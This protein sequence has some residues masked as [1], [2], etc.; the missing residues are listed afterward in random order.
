[1]FTAEKGFL[2]LEAMRILCGAGLLAPTRLLMTI[3]S[4]RYDILGGRYVKSPEL[5]ILLCEVELFREEVKTRRQEE[6]ALRLG[7]AYGMSNAKRN[8]LA[9]YP[10]GWRT[11]TTSVVGDCAPMCDCGATKCKTTHADW[12][13]VSK[14]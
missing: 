1:M 13:S 11:V 12:C 6:K 14:R 5:D 10:E 4:L 2:A 9:K 3:N 8:F 7:Q